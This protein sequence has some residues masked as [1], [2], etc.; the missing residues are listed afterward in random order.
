[1]WQRAR[2]K[3][4]VFY[5][6]INKYCRNFDL[7]WIAQWTTWHV[8]ATH[9]RNL[10]SVRA[11]DRKWLSM[12]R[13]HITSS[14]SFSSCHTSTLFLFTHTNG[15]HATE[16]VSFFIVFWRKQDWRSKFS[17]PIPRRCFAGDLFQLQN[18]R[19]AQKCF[20]LDEFGV[21]CYVICLPPITWHDILTDDEIQENHVRKSK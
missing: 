1:M 8:I 16:P 11:L 18:S 5:F 10:T 21:T 13:A 15:T 19:N 3:N 9:V 7:R 6:R 14:S 4:T 2:A 17:I 20:L 12:R